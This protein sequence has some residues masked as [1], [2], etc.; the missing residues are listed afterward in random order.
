MAQRLRKVTIGL[1]LALAGA[2]LVVSGLVLLLRAAWIAIA[3]PLGPIWA[4]SILG[5]ALLVVGALVIAFTA[6]AQRSS[7]SQ[8]DNDLLAALVSAFLQ[9]IAAGRSA[10]RR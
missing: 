4:S 5:V 1:A 6:L 7:R 10:R 9:G 3:L 2:G 8:S